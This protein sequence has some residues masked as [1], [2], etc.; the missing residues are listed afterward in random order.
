M[1]LSWTFL[2]TLLVAGVP[3]GQDTNFGTGPQYLI[4]NGSGLRPACT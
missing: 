2:F 3:P 1:R 4:T